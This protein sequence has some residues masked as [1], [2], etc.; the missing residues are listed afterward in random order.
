MIREQSDDAPRIMGIIWKSPPH[1]ADSAV[2][3]NE[4]LYVAIDDFA[5]RKRSSLLPLLAP[6]TGLKVTIITILNFGFHRCR[7]FPA[8][9]LPLKY[10]TWISF[11]TEEEYFRHILGL[12][13]I[14]CMSNGCCRTEGVIKRTSYD[15]ASLSTWLASWTFV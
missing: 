2:S 3:A 1:V 5:V 12:F 9:Y 15:I 10:H 6:S 13:R 4:Y 8:L 11:P 7:F 14:S